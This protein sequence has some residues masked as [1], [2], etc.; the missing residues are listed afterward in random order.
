M[1]RS[2]RR[3]RAKESFLRTDP[4]I[5]ARE[6]KIE[7]NLGTYY[8]EALM[9]C[10]ALAERKVHKFGQGRV[11]KSLSYIDEMMGKI[12]SGEVTVDDLKAELQKEIGVKIKV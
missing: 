7:D 6:K 10:F 11:L 1:N 5:R 4:M 2:E 3:R 9:T 8:V 12:G